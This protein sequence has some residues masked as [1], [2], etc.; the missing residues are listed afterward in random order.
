MSF[1]MRNYTSEEQFDLA[2]F[3]DFQEGVFDVINSPFLAK[4]KDLSTVDYYN[5]DERGFRDI[6]LIASDYYGNQFYAYLIQFYNS[7]FRD[8]FPEGTKLNMFSQ[9]D[10]NELY[11]SLANNSNMNNSE[12]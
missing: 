6:D 1:F 4:L 9:E 10:L 7:D 11:Y 5:V 3:L 8:T 12:V 2:K